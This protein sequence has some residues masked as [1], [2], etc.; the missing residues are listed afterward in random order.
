MRVT[1]QTIERPIKELQRTALGRIQFMSHWFYN[2]TSFGGCAL[3]APV[4][5]LGRSAGRATTKCADEGAK[6]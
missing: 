6:W 2:I 4:A 5:E 3:S 1:R